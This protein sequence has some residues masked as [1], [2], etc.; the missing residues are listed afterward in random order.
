VLFFG[1]TAAEP[2]SR[3]LAFRC[4][5]KA[6]YHPLRRRRAVSFAMA[7]RGTDLPRA[8]DDYLS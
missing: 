7:S 8:E 6:A 3:E 5:R 2:E 1:I 4:D